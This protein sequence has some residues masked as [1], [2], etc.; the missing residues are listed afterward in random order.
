MKRTLQFDYTTVGHVTIDIL[1]DG[2]RQP[3]GAA[4]YSALQ[5]ARLGRRTLI[6]TRGVAAE[7]ETLLEPYAGEL[8]VEIEPAPA[9]TTLQTSGW[10]SARSQR[11]ARVGRADPA[12]AAA[13]AAH[14]DPA[15]RPRRP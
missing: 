12:R 10:G 1:A 15:P 7:I 9:T 8:S 2:T 5:A 13:A 11:I 4:F 3:G 6:L 14:L